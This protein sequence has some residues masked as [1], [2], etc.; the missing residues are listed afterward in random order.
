VYLG[1]R[2][3]IIGGVLVVAGILI[4]DRCSQKE[5]RVMERRIS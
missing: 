5:L 2:N 4:T 1:K 3:Q